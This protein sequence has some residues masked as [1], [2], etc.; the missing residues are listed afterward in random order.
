MGVLQ[1]HISGLKQVELITIYSAQMAHHTSGMTAKVK[2]LE[3][4]AVAPHITMAL[5]IKLSGML[6]MTALAL[7]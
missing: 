6:A 5:A 4:M 2:V 7:A 1:T 3:L